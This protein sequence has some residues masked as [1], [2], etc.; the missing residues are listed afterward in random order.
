M[1]RS[2]DIRPTTTVSPEGRPARSN[3]SPH[4]LVLR[5]FLLVALVV[6]GAA[7]GGLVFGIPGGIIAALL[8]GSAAVIFNP[9][10]WAARKRIDDLESSD[11]VESA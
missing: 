1:K 6:G 8:V 9:E 2:T 7:A 5:I 3:A 4:R 10:I 11:G